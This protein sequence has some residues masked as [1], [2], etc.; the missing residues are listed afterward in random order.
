[1]DL[2]LSGRKALI[3]GGSRGIGKAIATA[4]SR[5]G[6]EVVL[7]ARDKDQLA[8][9]AEQIRSETGGSVS[10]LALD[11][12]APE[13]I[14]AMTGDFP[15][16]DI[17]VN[18]AGAV[19][20]GRLEDL[21]IEQI[22]Q[23][24][25]AKLFGYL[26][27]MQAYYP[28]MRARKSGAIV[29]VIGMAGARVNPDVIALSGGNAALIAMTR[30][31]G[32]EA[33]GFGVRVVGVNPGPTRTDRADMLLRERARRELG[34]ESRSAELTSDLPFGRL[35]MPEEIADV[36]AFLASPR[37]GYISGSVINVDGGL[38]ARP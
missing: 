21:S 33:P 1:M 11:L 15:D 19:L 23:S 28:L 13:S 9:S 34:D 3:T 12:G 16:I 2:E 20:P 35:C 36:V 30:A 6:C 29:N 18:N 38:G 24:W 17:L 26:S 7:V 14:P 32:G 5:E 10:T 22:R 37:A 31:L 4:L 25:D 27:L 8:K